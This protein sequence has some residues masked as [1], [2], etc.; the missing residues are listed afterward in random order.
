MLLQK[1]ENKKIISEQDDLFSGL[2]ALSE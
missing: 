1:E 2:G